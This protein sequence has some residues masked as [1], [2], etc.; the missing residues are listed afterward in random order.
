[1]PDKLAKNITKGITVTDAAT[2]SPISLPRNAQEI[3]TAQKQFESFLRDFVRIG[4][5]GKLQRDG[6]IYYD[7]YG[8][9]K[10]NRDI[11]STIDGTT[12]LHKGSMYGTEVANGASGTFG[13]V[14]P[15]TIKIASDSVEMTGGKFFKELITNRELEL[16][17]MP[18]LATNRIEMY[19]DGLEDEQIGVIK[20]ALVYAV[21]QTGAAATSFGY[22]NPGDRLLAKTYTE[23]EA[24]GLD[25]YS[26]IDKALKHKE[27]IG[28]EDGTGV[29][30]NYPFARGMN[31]GKS[32]T[33]AIS[34]SINRALTFAFKESP[35]GT[36]PGLEVSKTGQVSNLFGVKVYVFDLPQ[37][38]GKDFNWMVIEKGLHGAIAMPSVFDWESTIRPHYEGVS[39]LGKIIEGAG[40][41][42]GVKLMQPELIFAS[43]AA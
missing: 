28:R 25:A 40:G 34:S 41:S 32:S 20:A 10:M 33:L 16:E 24:G 6:K 14:A 37:K 42:F 38:A 22:T 19:R 1:M 13:Y 12:G 11:Q 27:K 4:G 5:K 9:A 39:V 3:I 2:K 43:F 8:K 36:F 30:T 23:D 17:N 21:G 15:T 18:T 31:I 26:D 7:F 35:S 29:E